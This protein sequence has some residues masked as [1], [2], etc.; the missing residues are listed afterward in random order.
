MSDATR[1]IL[2][3]WTLE[4]WP[5]TLCVVAAI[6]YLRGW[7]GLR[8]TMP[9]QFPPWRPVAFVAGLLSCWIAIASPL[10]AFAG[11][12]LQVHMA[13]HV[14]LMLIGPPLILL[15]SPGIPLLRGLPPA[16]RREWIGPFLASQGVRRGFH[17]LTHPVTG[18]V[19][20]VAATWLWHLPA[21]YELALRSD[22]W[23]EVE[24]AVF[25]SASLLFWWP[26]VQPWPSERVWP[27]IAIA[28]YLLTAGLQGTIFSAIFVF[29]EQPI[30]NHYA[31]TSPLLGMT[32]LQDQSAAG[33]IM[34]VGG[35]IAFIAA[36]SILVRNWLHGTA[37]MTLMPVGSVLGNR[38]ISLAML[39][40][41]GSI[42]TL[43]PSRRGPNDLLQARLLG[44]MLASLRVRRVAQSIMLLLAAAIIIDGLLGPTLSPMNLA[45]ILPWTYWRGFVIIAL[46]LAGNAF[47]WTCPFM[48]PRE[49]GKRWFRPIRAWPKAMR[50]KWI[51]AALLLAYLWSYEVFSLWDSPW[52]TVW[53]IIG[54]FT[55]ALVIDSCF[56]GAAFC[57]WVCP[58]GQFHFV[59]SMISPREV[60][61]LDT[62]TCE[63]CTTNDCI[64][65]GSGGR[66]CELDLYIPTKQGNYDCTFCMDCVR[67]CP[68]D[69]VGLITRPLHRDTLLGSWR[70]AI[71]RIGNRPDIA[72]IAAILTFGG[73]A[74]ALGMV[75]PVLD[76]QDAM[77]QR[78]GLSTHLLPA[79]MSLI[80][81]T[82]LVPAI[83]LWL[84][85]VLGRLLSQ[86]T[87]S[88]RTL[89]CR[90]SLALIPMGFAM[91]LVHML[92][93]LFTGLGTIVP[94][95]QR[96]AMD[97]GSSLGPPAWILACC[98]NI[99]DWVLPLELL[100]LDAGLVM[101]IVVLHHL[102][103][104]V[105]APGRAGRTLALW[106]LA[107]LAL[108]V[109]GVW[110]V[111]QPMQ[112]RGTLLP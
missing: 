104:E 93:H 56:R 61:A 90:L 89:S 83:V 85:G 98:L 12:S 107:P 49:L 24:H 45:G 109:V 8:R 67:A 92:F 63:R 34:W 26:V 102:S 37:Q 64:Q 35:G 51:A 88:V 30:Y 99:P 95:T 40:S 39:G 68:H 72:A 55:A 57:R 62:N 3:S 101:T 81:A 27:P 31:T 103:R 100:L 65:G 18:W 28:C 69:N 13:Q 1:A 46:L 106:S 29:F 43:K 19:A 71:G 96:V 79:T 66:G 38:T 50:S 41:A 21:L 5:L 73:F 48:L 105:S 20:F 70:G 53:V 17:V 84:F 42:R 58:I 4:P 9:Q 94:V 25:L 110:I 10:D 54:Y 78:W 22:L 77:A 32:V 44:R 80:V 14:L 76:F 74:N 7:T 82:V 52:W 112:M 11:L 15:G 75:G 108:F 16:I 59:E 87:E 23:H 6:V 86:S 2:S 97:L 36:A 33:A 47:C 60:A 91:W 111:L